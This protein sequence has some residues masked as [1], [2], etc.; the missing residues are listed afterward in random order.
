MQGQQWEAKM[1]PNSPTCLG[2]ASTAS[3]F[4]DMMCDDASFLDLR[5]KLRN[6]S[7]SVSSLPSLSLPSSKD[8]KAN[9]KPLFVA[10]SL[11][12]VT[13]RI[14]T[15]TSCIDWRGSVLRHVGWL[16]G[17][18]LHR[19]SGCR[20]GHSGRHPQVSPPPLPPEHGRSPARRR[21]G[22]HGPGKARQAHH[23]CGEGECVPLLSSPSRSSSL[24]FAL[25]F[26]FALLLSVAAQLVP[27]DIMVGLIKVELGKPACAKGFLLDGFPRTVGQGGWWWRSNVH[28]NSLVRCSRYAGPDAGLGEEA[29]QCRV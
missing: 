6:F 3:F 28:G 19:S 25:P 27:D 22:G 15:I 29:R 21:E 11:C 5:T 20:K 16:Q 7:S 4:V 1:V 14:A 2:S 18:H 26:L 13:A 8:P 10:S 23:G 17:H 12:A 24:F 9:Q